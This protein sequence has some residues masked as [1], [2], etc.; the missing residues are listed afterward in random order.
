V[1]LKSALGDALTTPDLTEVPIGWLRTPTDG[2]LLFS[3]LFALIE[4]GIEYG[5]VLLSFD[6]VWLDL[7]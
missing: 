7:L 4:E 5:C 1:V 3:R 6:R 2:D